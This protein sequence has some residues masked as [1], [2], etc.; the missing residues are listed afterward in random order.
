MASQIQ[1]RGDTK[2]NWESVNPILALKELVVET[3]TW[4]FKIGDGVSRYTALPYIFNSGEGKQK[5]FYQ[6]T[7][8]AVELVDAGDEW[9]DTNPDRE[10][11]KYTWTG[12]SFVNFN[13]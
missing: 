9:V 1:L 13:D 11:I 12:S 10:R 8:P 7:P 5:H 3:I 4:K 6:A 2:Q